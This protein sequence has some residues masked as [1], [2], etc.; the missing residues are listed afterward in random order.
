MQALI[1]VAL[2]IGP[3]SF[4]FLFDWFGNTTP[5]LAGGMLL[6]GSWVMTTITIANPSI[7]IRSTEDP[8]AQV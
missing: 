4:G 8:E 1:S 7:L 2:L 3:A 6:I 5:Y